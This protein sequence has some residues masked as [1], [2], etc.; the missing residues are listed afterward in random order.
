MWRWQFTTRRGPSISRHRNTGNIHRRDEPGH[1]PPPRSQCRSGVKPNGHRDPRR[2]DLARRAR[3]AA[4]HPSS[5]PRTAAARGRPRTDALEPAAQQEAVKPSPTNGRIRYRSP[6]AADLLPAD[7]LAAGPSAGD[8]AAAT[9]AAARMRRYSAAGARQQTE[10]VADRV[11]RYRGVLM[12]LLAPVLLISFVLLLMPRA[13]ASTSGGG[14]L[15]A[16][17]RRWGPRAVD[18]A[19][20][21]KYAVIFDAG[22]SGSRVHVYCFNGNLDLVPIGKEIELFK[23]KK[24]GLSA[25]AKDP[26]EAAES[27]VS[28]LEE[29]EKVVPAELREQTPVRVGV[30]NLL[31]DKSS[32][33]SQPDWVTVLD[34]SQE[35]A[36][37]WVTINY[38]LGKLG[39]PYANTVGVVDLGG[40]SVQMAYAISDKDAE[41]APQVSDG[42]YRYGDD[43]FE[44]SGSSSGASYSKC[45][46]LAVKALKADEPACT[47]MKCT[48]GGVWNGG[49]GD[50]QKNLF[51]GFVNPNEAVA[52]VKP[53][54]FEE[55]ARRVCKLNVKEAQATYPD[56]S[57]ENIPYLC[58]DLV[59]QY[60]LLV[61]G[62]G[63][64][65]YQD[66]TL[67]KK[68]PY[69]N[70]FVEAAWPLGSAIEVASSS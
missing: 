56:V 19:G 9:A 30:R 38:L 55:A 34:G 4:L 29:A 53:S 52:K 40:G 27:L 7:D 59:Y 64:D 26:Q 60:T 3:V 43:V 47:H 70:S 10:A 25:Y 17:G 6:S 49:G 8:A 63:V 32:F 22:S 1:S 41:K 14:L 58:I 65:P 5:P 24:P 31:H 45:R 61:D 11:H 2:G 37:Q 23:Q 66:I 15:A 13:P 21:H 44:A 18:D 54:D 12:V 20:S 39:K 33:K 35:G 51:A 46:D 67:V 16:G 57:P 48:F 62:F 50:G 36:F 69:S 42:K 28:L 68:V